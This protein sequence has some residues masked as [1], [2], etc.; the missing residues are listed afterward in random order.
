ML[1]HHTSRQTAREA[2]IRRGMEFIYGLAKHRKHF[3]KCGDDLLYFYSRVARTS[4][5]SGLRKM[6]G[7]MLKER[8]PHWRYDRK[9]FPPNPDADLILEYFYKAFTAEHLGVRD[10][11]MKRQLR[12]AARRFTAAEV[13]WF[14]PY[15]E[16]PPTDV[17]EVCFGC[18]GWNGRGRRICLWCSRRLAMMTRY[19]VWYYS[20][21]RA[22]CAETYGITLGARYLEVLKRLP[23]LRP[24]PASRNGT[25]PDFTDAVYAISHIVYT[26]N[27]Y[28]VYRLSPHW[29]PAEY[30]FLKS[31]LEEAIAL[32]DAD[33]M[34]E[35]LDSLMAFGL[36]DRHPLLRLGQDFLLSRQNAD[37]SWGEVDTEDLYSRYHPT[38]AAI[39]GLREYAWRGQELKFPQAMPLLKLWASNKG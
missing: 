1:A 21:T 15:A 25:D 29:L 4:R 39:D 30:E 24:Y 10:N 9:P 35:F 3:A 2:A 14:D 6:A 23:A 27:D 17:P 7:A 13:L 31:N 26:L 32:D 36:T 19:Q 37:G 38:W 34:G 11:A 20:L 16:T 8:L 5:D 12:E 33:M 22:Y 18:G 28:G